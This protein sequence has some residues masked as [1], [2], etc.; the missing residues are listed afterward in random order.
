MIIRNLVNFAL[1]R[2]IRRLWG[3]QPTV[4][5]MRKTYMHADRLASF[6][7]RRV[8]VSIDMVGGVAVDDRTAR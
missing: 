8:T 2:T 3:A 6:G 5:K 4:E 7:R 1:K